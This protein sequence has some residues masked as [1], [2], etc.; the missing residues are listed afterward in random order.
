MAGETRVA[1]M[2]GRS[3]GGDDSRRTQVGNQSTAWTNDH[4]GVE[5]GR[6]HGRDLEGGSRCMIDLDR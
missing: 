3:Q 6:S 4:S 2:G 1:M 5:G